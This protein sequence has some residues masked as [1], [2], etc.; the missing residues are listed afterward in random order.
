MGLSTIPVMNLLRTVCLIIILFI[1]TLSGCGKKSDSRADTFYYNQPEG[2]RTLDPA[3]A[4]NQPVM[5]AVHQL[6]STLTEVDSQLNIVSALAKEWTLSADRLTY[7]FLLRSDVFFHD[8]PVFPQG[9]GRRLI[10]GDVVYSFNR[11]IDP[12]V[13][14]SGAWIFN[15]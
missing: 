9:K 10:A 2:I 3:Y 1:H 7:R 6:Y 11:I 12:A 5:W 15:T 4:K 8:H 14:S 13:A